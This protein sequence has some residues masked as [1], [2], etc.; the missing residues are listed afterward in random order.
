M[1]QTDTVVSQKLSHSSLTLMQNVT[2]TNALLLA[3]LHKVAYKFRCNS[4]KLYLQ[5]SN[6][7]PKY[8]CVLI[9]LGVP[10]TSVHDLN[11][12]SAVGHCTA[13]SVM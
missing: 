6:L 3:Q 10:M 1:A 7:P 8:L 2:T 5:W 4:A 12:D 13:E 11:I 9:Y